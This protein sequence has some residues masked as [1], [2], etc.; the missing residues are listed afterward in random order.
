MRNLLMPQVQG[1]RRERYQEVHRILEMALVELLVEVEPLVAVEFLVAAVAVVAVELLVA[2]VVDEQPVDELVVA[3][4]V[5]VQ[6]EVGVNAQV[7]HDVL[8]LLL[9][10]LVGGVDS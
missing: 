9:R 10:R 7:Q 5:E 2:V 1:C 6:V 3:E 4:E 8:M